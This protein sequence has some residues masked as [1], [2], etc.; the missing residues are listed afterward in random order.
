MGVEELLLVGVS[1]LLPSFSPALKLQRQKVHSAQDEKPLQHLQSPGILYSMDSGVSLTSKEIK[2]FLLSS[3][4]T[5]T[6]AACL[7]TSTFVKKKEN[8]NSGNQ[9]L[10]VRQYTCIRRVT[11]KGHCHAIWQLYKKL[12]GVLASIKFQN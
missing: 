10:N 1:V 4:E 8:C 6:T 9:S 3:S 5:N 7:N 11:L 2:R 12:E